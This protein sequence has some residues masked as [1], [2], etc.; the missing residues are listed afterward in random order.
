MNTKELRKKV[1]KYK[2]NNK[3][4][5]YDVGLEIGISSNTV[6]RFCNGEEVL[7]RILAEI[8]RFFAAPCIKPPEEQKYIKALEKVK[9][10]LLKMKEADD[11]MTECFYLDR[12]CNRCSKE[13]CVSY[14][15]NTIE[16][17]VNEVL[18]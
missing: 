14:W 16:S 18:Q 7:P 13:K 17:A 2:E 12:Q 10:C 3:I 8:E 5:Y 9:R 1:I 4:S 11:I 15:Y 6:R